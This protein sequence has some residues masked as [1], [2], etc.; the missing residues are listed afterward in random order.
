MRDG[1]E[2]PLE[3]P[4]IIA[5]EVQECLDDRI[6]DGLPVTIETREVVLTPG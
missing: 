2:D 3:T 6:E 5:R 1:L 4:E